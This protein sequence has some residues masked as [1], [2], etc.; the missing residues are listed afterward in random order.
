MHNRN[1][2]ASILPSDWIAEICISGLQTTNNFKCCCWIAWCLKYLNSKSGKSGSR[3]CSHAEYMQTY[4]YCIFHIHIQ[5]QYYLDIVSLRLCYV[6]Y[7]SNELLFLI[8]IATATKTS[9]HNR[10]PIFNLKCM[11]NNKFKKYVL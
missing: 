11:L 2:M 8:N 10:I 4:Y 6:Y 1:V 7:R 3:K 5:I 9:Q